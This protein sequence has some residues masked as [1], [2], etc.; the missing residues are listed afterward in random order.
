V[1]QE[2]KFAVWS[3][4]MWAVKYCLASAGGTSALIK[5]LMDERPDLDP[6]KVFDLSASKDSDSFT[7]SKEHS[8]KAASVL[9]SESVLLKSLGAKLAPLPSD[10]AMLSP[11]PARV[12][13]S[14]AMELQMPVKVRE[15]LGYAPQMKDLTEVMGKL[16]PNM[17]GSAIYG[18]GNENEPLGL[19]RSAGVKK[20][21]FE[22]IEQDTVS[23]LME[24]FL[25]SNPA[26]QKPGWLIGLGAFKKIGLMKSPDGGFCGYKMME[27]SLEGIPCFRLK[28]VEEDDPAGDRPF[29]IFLGDWAEFTIRTDRAVKIRCVKDFRVKGGMIATTSI[30]YD[31]CKDPKRFVAGRRVAAR[32]PES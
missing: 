4:Y 32:K 28:I 31:F 9:L 17:D 22:D 5:R 24:L 6:G 30:S 2:E 26:A 11:Q 29:D 1:N 16:G 3:D 25:K 10:M 23:R 12:P 13:K 8:E 15:F 7:L 21:R 19:L 20:L 18:T 27:G 14:R